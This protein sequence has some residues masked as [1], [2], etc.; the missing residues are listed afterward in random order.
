VVTLS[1]SSEFEGVSVG[2]LFACAF[3][4]GRSCWFLTRTARRGPGAGGLNDAVGHGLLRRVGTRYALNDDDW[5]ASFSAPA[6]KGAP[7]TRPGAPSATRPIKATKGAHAR[8]VPALG[9]VGGHRQVHL[10]L[11]W[12]LSQLCWMSFAPFAVEAFSTVRR[13]ALL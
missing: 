7:G 9:V 13:S 5:E 11:F 8:S 12:V 10:S 4:L 3:G 2:L 1:S 6:P